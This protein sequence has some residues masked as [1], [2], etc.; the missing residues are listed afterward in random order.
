MHHFIFPTKDTYIS[1]GSS[2]IDGESYKDKNYGQDE[3]LELKKEF[4]NKEFDY[5]TRVL[6]Q[7]NLT[8]LTQSLVNGDITNPRYYL[9]LYE[10]EG[11]QDMTPNYT[12][13]AQAISQSW[14]EGA[15]KD[16]HNPKTT[17]GVSWE[18]RSFRPDT[19]ATSWETGGVTTYNVNGASQ[20][21]S[22]E[23]PDVNMDITGIVNSWL[24]GSNKINDDGILLRFSGSGET[25]NKTFGDL[26]FFSR[27]TNT[28]YSPRLE[29]RW[30][31][32]TTIS[33][34]EDTTGTL[35]SLDLSGT[36]PIHIYPKNL[37]NKYR[38]TE[39]VKFRFG[40]RKQY[41]PK[42]F[43]TTVQTLSGS[44]FG[45]GSGSYSIIDIGTN[46]TIVPFSAHTSMSCDATSPYFIQWMD[47]FYPDRH[48]KI[49]VKLKY[50]DGQEVIY[51]NNYEFKVVR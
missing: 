28:I 49:I 8:S 27:N 5:P 11:N 16:S 35:T 43:A 22:Y 19:T 2:H 45:E 31:D 34:S 42:T 33:Q 3:I 47:G 10:A 6:L 9:R 21:F 38:E 30:D 41:V 20:S 15:G 14:E 40:C 39:K 32:H 17:N 26:K 36:Y 25:D 7:F 37:K 13:S 29:V 1:S 46:E 48:Y 18:N 4:F 23:S 50:N 24:G 44:Y 51:D 12:L